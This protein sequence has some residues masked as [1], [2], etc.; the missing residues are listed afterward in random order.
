MRVLISRNYKALAK[1]R[2]DSDGG[3]TGPCREFLPWQ[4]CLKTLFAKISELI[5]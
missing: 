2:K 5:V 3:E 1:W 4:I